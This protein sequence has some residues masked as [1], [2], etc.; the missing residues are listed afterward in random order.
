MALLF[1]FSSPVFAATLTEDEAS[2]M[3]KIEKA[4]IQ[5][6]SHLRKRYEGYKVT[7][8]NKYPSNLEVTSASIDNG[9][10]GT[11]AAGNTATSYVNILWGLPL[12]LLGMGI[13]A[14]VISNKNH[15][16]ETESF[17]FSNQIPTPTLH[18]NENMTFN[19]LVPVGQTPQI[20]LHFSDSANNLEFSKSII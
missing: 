15:K 13:A 6:Q 7:I 17:Q 8:T 12:W 5:L 1:S 10:A 9:V 11:V 19:T 4:P 18:K 16:A 2:Q 3:I 20:K 14:A